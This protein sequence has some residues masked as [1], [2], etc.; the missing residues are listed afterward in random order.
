MPISPYIRQLPVLDLEQLSVI[1]EAT[2]DAA[3]L[4]AELL[5]LFEQESTHH[6]TSLAGM[7][8]DGDLI[9][10][11]KEA[12]A[13]AGSAA[14][15]GGKR[16][17]SVAREIQRGLDEGEADV[18]ATAEGQLREEREAFVAAFRGEMAKV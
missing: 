5:G 9:A 14:N 3:E 13:I 4:M 2:D 7:L 8:S 16:L 12:H 17:A 15:L 1:R 10:A 6:L 18:A 11:S